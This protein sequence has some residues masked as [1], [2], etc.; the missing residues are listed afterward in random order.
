MGDLKTTSEAA[1]ILGLSAKR[2]RE[3]A[4]GGV[5]PGRR[6]GRDW[7]FGAKDLAR[8]GKISRP[9]GWPKGRPRKTPARPG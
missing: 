1:E 8:F 2:V 9:R 5:L 4:L 7:L 3:L 6:I